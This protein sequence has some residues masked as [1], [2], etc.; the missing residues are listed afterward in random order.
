V[1]NWSPATHADQPSPPRSKG[2]GEAH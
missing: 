2:R 1:I